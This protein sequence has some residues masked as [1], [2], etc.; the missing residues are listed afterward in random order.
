[1]RGGQRNIFFRK[2]RRKEEV[3]HKERLFWAEGERIQKKSLGKETLS[4]EEMD[5]SFSSLIPCEEK[6][7]KALE[8]K[9]P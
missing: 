8:A 4:E 9:A 6:K 3:Q 2:A 5:G 1:V 7:G